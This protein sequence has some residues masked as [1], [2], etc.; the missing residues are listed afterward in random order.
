MRCRYS[1]RRSDRRGSSPSSACTSCSAAG[2]TGR[3]LGCARAPRRGPR[4]EMSMVAVADFMR[5][6]RRRSIEEV[7]KLVDV[8]RE[9]QRMLAHEPLGELGITA[10]Q[11]L[12]DLHV[13]DYA[14][15]GAIGLRDG[16]PA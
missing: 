10:L 4:A 9:V 12:D 5:W 15:R 13:I 16:Q 11:R 6:R 1:M 8:R 2:S 3:P 14:P 7:A